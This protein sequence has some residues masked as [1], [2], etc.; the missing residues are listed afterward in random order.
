MLE[1]HWM[2]TWYTREN[3]PNLRK[4]IFI[5]SLFILFIYLIL[6]AFGSMSGWSTTL[7]W[8][9]PWVLYPPPGAGA[10]A[11]R[12]RAPWRTARPTTRRRTTSCRANR[13][14][15]SAPKWEDGP[16]VFLDAMGWWDGGQLNVCLVV[17]FWP[18]GMH[19]IRMTSS[20][21]PGAQHFFLSWHGSKF[22]TDPIQKSESESWKQ[23]FPPDLLAWS[24][25]SRGN[26][27]I[28]TRSTTHSTRRFYRCE[29]QKSERCFDGYLANRITYLCHFL[30]QIHISIATKI[31]IHN[32][33][34]LN[35]DSCNKTGCSQVGFQNRWIFGFSFG[36]S[37]SGFA[38]S[39]Q[40][41]RL[42][43]LCE[44]HYADV[45]LTLAYA[46]VYFRGAAAWKNQ[47]FFA[48]KT[49]GGPDAEVPLPPLATR[50]ATMRWKIKDQRFL[51]WIIDLI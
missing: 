30:S 3:I 38:T 21:S 51:I 7:T 15:G 29:I 5:Q 23:Q 43:H 24:T 37:G 16:M 27:W 14:S 49:K 40:G 36:I 22:T 25:A 47:T 42:M 41:I 8:W 13:R 6:S 31:S 2:D 26:V 19:I 33:I 12:P 50:W 9:P 10:P 17:V 4:P 28:P 1:Y 46:S 44:Y 34:V 48:E 11:E 45:V 18:P 20:W 32:F 35:Y 39:F